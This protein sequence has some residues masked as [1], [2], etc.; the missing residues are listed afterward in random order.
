MD[1]MHPTA[2]LVIKLSIAYKHTCESIGNGPGYQGDLSQGVG[3][4]G[5]GLARRDSKGGI[6]ANGTVLREEARRVVPA[7]AIP[8]DANPGEA[9]R[10][11]DVSD[12]RL[13]DGVGHVGEVALPPY[14]DIKAGIGRQRV[15]CRLPL[16]GVDGHGEVP[17]AGVAVCHPVGT[18]RLL[19]SVGPGQVGDEGA[20]GDDCCC[21]SVF[22]LPQSIRDCQ[23]VD[24]W[25]KQDCLVG[26][27]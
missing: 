1:V 8:G 20:S 19:V 12:G 13:D 2:V 22:Y 16:E 3:D 7:E 17:C 6:R 24:I 27:S 9:E 5:R 11:A 4:A 10:V 14:P 15:R 25:E 26:T 23:S 21:A 18:R